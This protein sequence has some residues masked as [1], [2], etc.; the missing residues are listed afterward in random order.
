MIPLP[1]VIDDVLGVPF[2]LGGRDWRDT[3]DC[4]GLVIAGA[5]VW[6]IAVP[7]LWGAVAAE[8]A[9]TNGVVLPAELPGAERVASVR[10]AR[11]GDV[12]AC[13]GASGSVSHVVLVE[14]DGWCL[15]TA[16]GE[17]SRRIELRRFAAAVH[18]VWRF[19]CSR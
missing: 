12:L 17:S 18:S 5:A 15:S 6:G 9:A 8:Y 13:Q 4:H 16:R 19:P 1:T 7:D 3:L 10:D 2:R 11:R 14:G